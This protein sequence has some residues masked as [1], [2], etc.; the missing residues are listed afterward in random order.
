MQVFTRSSASGRSRVAR[1]AA[2]AVAAAV[3]LTGGPGVAAAQTPAQLGRAPEHAAVSCW[4]IKQKDP[5]APDGSYW[6]LTPR[7]AGPQQFH[8]DMTTDGGGWVLI[9]RGR[10]GWTFGYNGQGTAEQVRTVVDGTGAFVPRAL[11]GKVIDGLLNGTRVDG[12]TD[13][14]RLRRSA[15]STGTTRQEARFRFRN[16]D[17]WAWT[18]AANHPLAGYRFDTRSYTGGGT[19]NFGA[20]S[21][22]RRV[23]TAERESQGWRAGWAFGSFV[24]GANNA[25]THLWSATGRSPMPFTQ[26]YLR[27]RL[28]AE[29]TPFPAIPDPGAPAI[30]Q[31]PLASNQ[32]LPA[33]WGVTGLANGRSGELNT[34]VSAFT[35]SGDRMLVGGN[36]RFV[37]KGENAAGAD[38]VEQSYLAAFDVASGNWLPD[39]RPVFNG[40]VKALHTVPNGVVVA[41]GEFTTVNGTPAVGVVALNATT[42]QIDP[43]FRVAMENRVSGQTVTVTSFDAEGRW[44]YIGGRFT[45]LAGG[46]RAN[47]ISARMAARVALAEGTPDAGWIPDLDGSVVDVDASPSGDRVYLAGYFDTAKGVSAPK[48]AVLDTTTGAVVP[49]LGRPSFSNATNYQQAVREVGDRVW[50]GGAQHMIFSYRRSD[51]TRLSGNI[52][53]EGGDFQTIHSQNGVVYG[54][55]HCNDWNYS[56]AY[57]FRNVGTNWSQADDIGFTG[58]WD[59]VT[60]LYLPEFHPGLRAAR[61]HGPWDMV[62]DSLGNLWMG[63]DFNRARTAGDA[64]Q[65]VGGFVRF[66]ERDSRAPTVPAGPTRSD[67]GGTTTLAWRAS[68]DDRGGVEY[69]IL[70]DNRVIGRT[71]ATQVSLPNAGGGGRFFV[72]AIDGAGNRSATTPVVTAAPK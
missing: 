38:R 37:Q 11:S 32:T 48:V 1:A 57:A 51:M 68:T 65:W 50:H 66:A 18:M 58:A 35:Q 14:V 22:Y 40:Q 49:G 3:A 46:T 47:P 13:G 67:A 71:W 69:E 16:R 4:D 24:S 43:S 59:A 6:L 12:L 60:G 39:F 33:P 28:T 55:C 44:L 54:G 45:H 53:V 63:G 21:S 17:R 34:E 61:G 8:C 2:T 23:Q 64:W 70:R 15:N 52:T 31:A 41:G 20:D 19:L 62:T 9:G 26:V 29:N 72:R 27:P 25:T 10:E 36:F 7:L 30:A 42:G 5:S 56:E